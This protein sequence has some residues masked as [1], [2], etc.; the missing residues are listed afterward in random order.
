MLEDI[1][2]DLAENYDESD[3]TI[4]E[5]MLEAV[6][7]TALNISNRNDTEENRNLL[8]LEIS[9]AVKALYLARG[10]EGL[11]SLND[12]GKSSSF[13]DVIEKLRNNIIKN[14]KRKNRF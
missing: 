2:K 4:L 8:S 10:G 3:E 9:N 13:E 12:G 6:T 7:T 5:N 14:G 1:I 11:N